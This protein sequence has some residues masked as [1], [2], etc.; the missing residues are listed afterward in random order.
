MKASSKGYQIKVPVYVSE[1]MERD[2]NGAIFPTSSSSLIDDAKA[3]IRTYNSNPEAILTSNKRNKTTTIGIKSIDVEEISFNEDPC[4]LL[5][6]TAYK[7]NLI[8]GYYQSASE[9]GRQIR[10]KEQDKICSDT[11]CFILYPLLNTQ[12]EDGLKIDV[13]WHI[14]IYE[15][16][17]KTNEEMARIARLIMGKILKTPIKNIKSDKMLADIK[18]YGLI[19]EVEISLSVEEDDDKGIPEYIKNYQFSSTL[20]QEKK[21]KL[22]NMS[23]DDAISAFEDESFAKHFSKRQLKFVT[24]NK[25]VFSVVQE[26]KDKMS[27]ALEDN[28]NYSIDVNEEDIKDGSIFKTEIIQRNV[29]GIFTRYMSDCNDNG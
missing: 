29:A 5:R 25:R 9:E 1:K 6:V 17:S 10:F 22:S 23:A 14:F 16:P 24:H 7:T 18:K 8:D 4:L 19:S 2:N 11:Y 20:K 15:D 21:I 3:L 27:S 26:F 28:F 12:I 13:Y